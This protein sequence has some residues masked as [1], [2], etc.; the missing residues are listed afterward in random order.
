MIASSS[1]LSNIDHIKKR[2]ELD[3][4]HQRSQLAINLLDNIC[5]GHRS[6]IFKQGATAIQ[7]HNHSILRKHI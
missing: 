7:Q 4:A 6:A 5:V 3:S 2:A 1:I